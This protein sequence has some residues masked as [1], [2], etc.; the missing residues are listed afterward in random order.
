MV[1]PCGRAKVWHRHPEL[2]PVAARH[3]YPGPPFK[4]NREYAERFGEEWV[5][6][7]AKYGFISPDFRIPGPYEVTFKRPSTC[8]V[9]LEVLREQVRRMELHRFSDVIGLG[10]AKYRTRVQKAF[11]SLPV[12]LHFPFRGLAIGKAMA[13]IKRAINSGCPF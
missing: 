3:A 6:L 7:S 10:G 11:E 4:V 9:T 12:S 2:G 5:I 8:P 13:A 1:V